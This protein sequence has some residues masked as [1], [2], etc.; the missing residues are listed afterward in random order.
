ML[1]TPQVWSRS[2][3][4]PGVVTEFDAGDVVQGLGAVVLG[5]EHQTRDSQ[6]SS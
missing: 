1:S 2:L 6:N 5:I 3:S 4:G